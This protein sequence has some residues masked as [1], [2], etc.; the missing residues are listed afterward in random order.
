VRHVGRRARL[1]H[2]AGGALTA[3]EGT[4]RSGS[5]ACSRGAPDDERLVRVALRGEGD[6]VVGALQ[7]REGVRLGVAPQL[8]AALARLAVHHACAAPGPP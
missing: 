1:R 4:R 6:D 2:V 5:G 7:L 3:L 8:H